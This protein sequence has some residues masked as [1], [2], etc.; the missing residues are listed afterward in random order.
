VGSRANCLLRKGDNVIKPWN[1]FWFVDH[2][3]PQKK[4]T[5]FKNI[6]RKGCFLFMYLFIYLNVLE[7]IELSSL[8][9]MRHL[10]AKDV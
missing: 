5:A 3:N 8:E 6:F 9:W 2:Q 1:R 4:N 10:Q 7:Q